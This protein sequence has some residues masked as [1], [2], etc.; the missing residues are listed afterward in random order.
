MCIFSSP[1]TSKVSTQ[2]GIGISE[3]YFTF[4]GTY[5]PTAQCSA[6]PTNAQH[7]TCQLLHSTKE[8]RSFI[9]LRYRCFH[10][11]NDGNRSKGMHYHRLIGDIAICT[12]VGRVLQ[13]YS[14][15]DVYSTSRDVTLSSASSSAEVFLL[16]MIYGYAVVD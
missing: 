3:E 14:P 1:P 8:K 11:Q 12:V 4:S 6:C 13:V 9:S 10:P 2:L 5:A 16:G 15:D 7:I